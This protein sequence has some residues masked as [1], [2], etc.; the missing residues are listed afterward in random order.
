MKKLLYLIPV[1]L[2]MMSCASADKMLERGDYDS[3]IRYASKKLTGKKKKDH[4]VKAL[5]S[6]FDKMIKRDMARIESRQQANTAEDWEEVIQ[7]A[8][9][10]ERKQSRIE[11]FLPLVSESGYQAKFTFVRTGKII[12]EARTNAV[13]LHEKRLGDLANAARN[14]NKYAAREAYHLIDHIRA[15]SSDYYNASL[16]DEMWNLGIN[17]VLVHIENESGAILPGNFEEELLSVDFAN[18]GGNWDRFY[19]HMDKNEKVDYE[20][21]LRL[22]D[23][24][25]TPEQL[26]ESQRQY[27]REVKDGW[28]YVLDARGNVAKDS[29]GNDIK[30]DK[31]IKVSATVVETNQRKNAIVHARMDIYDKSGGTRIFSQPLDAEN[32]FTHTARNYFGDERALDQ[33]QRQKIAPIPYPSDLIMIMDA[34]KALKPKFFKEVK[35]FNYAR[36]S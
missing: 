2:M 1:A 8:G 27:T 29:L 23:I 28:E 20:V 18:A 7:I 6:G 10:I 12:S 32:V 36:N 5:E 15:V 34:L 11:P 25:T 4:L 31:Y 14:G 35:D 33:G 22:L 9:D 3:L 17:R 26:S 30:R 16:H 13:L 19:T 21:V 24:A